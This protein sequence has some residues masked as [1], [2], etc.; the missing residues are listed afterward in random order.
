M[1][2][3]KVCHEDGACPFAFFSDL[4]DYAQNMGYLPTPNEIRNMRVNHGKTWACHDK[5][6]TPCVGSIKW[7]KE[8]GLPYEVIDPI[9]L[10]EKSR[11]DLYVK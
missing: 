3:V 2:C 7:L 4:S 11:W 5:P 1:T 8:Q 10:T 9:L 6:D